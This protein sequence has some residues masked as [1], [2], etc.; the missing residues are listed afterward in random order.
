MLIGTGF[1][2]SVGVDS[3]WEKLKKILIKKIIE[4]NMIQPASLNKVKKL[5]KKKKREINLYS[6]EYLKKKHGLKING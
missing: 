4:T 6:E 1:Q 3:S 2:I 5:V